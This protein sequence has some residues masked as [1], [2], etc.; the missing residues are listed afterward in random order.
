MKPV[1]PYDRAKNGKTFKSP[2]T[3][4]SPEQMSEELLTFPWRRFARAQKL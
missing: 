1:S 3:V 4:F 2:D